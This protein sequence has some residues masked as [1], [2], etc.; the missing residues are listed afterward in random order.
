M[1]GHS[2]HTST[3]AGRCRWRVPR[4]EE[5]CTGILSPFRVQCL[6]AKTVTG[7]ARSLSSVDRGRR[8]SVVIVCLRAFVLPI[9]PREHKRKREENGDLNPSGKFPELSHSV[10]LLACLGPPV[11]RATR[12]DCITHQFPN[13]RALVNA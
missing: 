7:C 11:V 2:S 3:P 9:S 4:I 5:T 6:A 10:Y 13:H 1:M 12:L 8:L